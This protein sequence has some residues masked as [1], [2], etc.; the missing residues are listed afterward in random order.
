MP[1]V[2]IKDIAL[3]AGISKTAVSFAFNN[4]TRLSDTTLKHILA[5]AEEMGYS[6]NPVARSMSTG[7]TG[8]IG[9]LVPQPINEIVRNPHFPEFVEG[10]G[11][12]C[13]LSGLSLM[14][15]PPLKG[16]MRRA[17]DNAA[18]DGFLTLGLEEDK[19]TMVVVRQCR[20]PFVTI[21]SDPIEGIPAINVDDNGGA[22]QAMQYLLELGHRNI[23]ILAIRSG[24]Q[25]RYQE[26]VGT[27]GARMR[28]YLTALDK[29][30]L[31][32]NGRSVHLLE[33]ISTEDG[34]VEGFKALWRFRN[35]PT[36][37]IA[38]SDII[39]IGVIKAATASGLNVPKDLSVLGFDDIALASLI[40]PALT[41]VSQPSI[42]KGRQ[43]ASLLVKLIEST[44]EPSHQI[45]PTQLVI[46]ESVCPP[47][48]G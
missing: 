28:G 41:T 35:K 19:A 33:C 46:R 44:V 27:L 15:V 42:E 5:I 8:A 18:V 40:H 11:E 4:P 12:V 7:R 38:M 13:T 23:V 25:A 20:V 17:I 37:I 48:H 29:Y 39:A 47:N 1:K 3:K 36:A 32:I 2:N 43:A 30:G 26:Y 14:L 31:T 21:D 16:S 9:L 24:K 45:L 34:G 10:I 6:P 22:N